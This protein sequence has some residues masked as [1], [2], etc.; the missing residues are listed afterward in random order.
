MSYGVGKIGQG[1]KGLGSTVDATT[2]VANAA[3]KTPG[4]FGKI[5]GGIG[6][7][8]NPAEGTPGIFKGSIGPNIRRGIGGLFGGMGPSEG[9]MT[10]GEQE[11][12]FQDGDGNTYSAS[13]V[14]EML[15][16]GTQPDNLFQVQ[17]SGVQSSGVQ[18]SGVQSSGSPFN[19]GRAILGKGNTPG[20]IKGIEDSIKGP[21]GRIGGGDGSFMGVGSGGL[22]PGMMAMAALYG[23]A[24][25]E[26]FKRKE[27]GMKDV[28]QSIRP[29]L[30]PQQTFQGFDLGVRKNAAMGGFQELDMRMGGPS[31]G[32]GTGTSDDIPAM[33]SDGEFVQ[34]AKANNG[35]GGFKVTKT[36]TGIEMIPNGKPSRKKGAKNMDT[37]MK[38]FENY[39]DIGRV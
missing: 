1:I 11:L 29:D 10:G 19:I 2:G 36:E 3:S 38:M 23:K 28:R 18:S 20:F 25:K 32:P 26:D 15:A 4:F 7:F 22:N 13:K 14:E 31:I 8:F 6:S 33:L 21:D 39:N 24:V 30:M 16:A 5:K 17:S 37:L 12:M 35:L 34:T 27:G 9:P